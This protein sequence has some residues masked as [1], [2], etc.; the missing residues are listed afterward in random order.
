MVE[1]TNLLVITARCCVEATLFYGAF[2]LQVFGLLLL[3]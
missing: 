2:R 3:L 1:G